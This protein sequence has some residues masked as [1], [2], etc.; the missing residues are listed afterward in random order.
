MAEG[1]I[2]PANTTPKESD[3]VNVMDAMR[4][5]L[6]A[7]INAINDAM[8]FD[9]KD[10]GEGI[11]DMPK[12]LLAAQNI[13]VQWTENIVP[14]VFA[15]FVKALDIDTTKPMIEE[16]P[17][18]QLD[19]NVAAMINAAAEFQMNLMNRQA[20]ERQRLTQKLQTGVAG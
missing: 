3:G 12:T 5:A 15:N 18:M 17:Y 10:I 14:A 11:A 8:G 13:P 9:P 6:E 1:L 7:A 19:E 4:Q 16:F 20:Q 2:M